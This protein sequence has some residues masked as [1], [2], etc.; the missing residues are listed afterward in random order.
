[1]DQRR[2]ILLSALLL[3]IIAGGIQWYD[4]S[5]SPAHETTTEQRQL[6]PESIVSDFSQTTFAE[7]GAR[8]YHLSAERVT[9]FSRQAAAEMTRPDIL[10]YRNQSSAGKDQEPAAIDWQASA[11]SGIILEDQDT[12]TLTGSVRVTKPLAGE[13]TLNFDT[14]SLTIKPKAEE[15]S[16]ADPVT[17]TQALHVTR[18]TGLHIDI[19][20]GKVELL[21]QV[22]S[23]YVPARTQPE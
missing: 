13:Q 18:A 22:R 21:S 4:R 9:H 8:Q 14:E 11:A 7:S 1:M 17:V 15:A 16:T 6:A 5:V 12:L 19:A 2:L 3:A 20:A 23:Q 10:F